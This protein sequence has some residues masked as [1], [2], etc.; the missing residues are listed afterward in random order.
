M[1]Q[2]CN[3]NDDTQPTEFAIL[4][5]E[6]APTNPIAIEHQSLVETRQE[7][8]PVMKTPAINQVSEDVS[9]GTSE[10]YPN[11]QT[12]QS[13]LMDNA[14]MQLM[15][16]KEVLRYVAEIKQANKEL[17]AH[18][19]KMN[20]EKTQLLNY[21]DNLKQASYTM[22]A[23][24][25]KTQEAAASTADMYAL[26]CE[27]KAEANT[28]IEELESWI[29]ELDSA[30]NSERQKTETAESA[31]KAAQDEVQRVREQLNQAIA[32]VKKE[33]Q[34][35]VEAQE[36][37]RLENEWAKKAERE[38]VDMAERLKNMGNDNLWALGVARRA[39]EK[40]IEA[41]QRAKTAEK[42]H[43][44]LATEVEQL[45]ATVK[46]AA[47]RVVQSKLLAVG[48]IEVAVDGPGQPERKRKGLQEGEPRPPVT[49][50]AKNKILPRPRRGTID[51]RIWQSS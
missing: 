34:S 48:E 6:A 49:A 29:S 38:R 1:Q 3:R 44:V 21:I 18:L 28:A 20:E 37:M 5:P 36:A 45:Q 47:E 14:T 17:N 13:N 50:N 33:R 30:V 40:S 9:A 46:G 43:Q 12:S 23:H 42:A 7:R 11:Q 35:R 25:T 4:P 31:K 27:Q 16:D 24:V 10:S 19:M 2:T 8:A 41:K 26:A 39:K 32:T 15:R 22:T 51:C